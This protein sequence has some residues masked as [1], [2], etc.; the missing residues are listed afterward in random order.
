MARVTCCH[1]LK[2]EGDEGEKQKQQVQTFDRLLSSPL[3]LKLAL[4]LRRDGAAGQTT[5]PQ[6]RGRVPERVHRSRLLVIDEDLAVLW[7]MGGGG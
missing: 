4:L 7:T 5:L 1:S 6:L 3:R 2:G